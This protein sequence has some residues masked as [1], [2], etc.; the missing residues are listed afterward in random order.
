M[1]FISHDLTVVR[2]VCHR[3]VVLHRGEI[4]EQGR[5]EQI[6]DHPQHEDTQALLA[7]SPVPDP[8]EQRHRRE[9]RRQRRLAVLKAA[10]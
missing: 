4:V 8:V 7:A 5:T 10:G 6:H 1:L 2:H 3:T 9:L